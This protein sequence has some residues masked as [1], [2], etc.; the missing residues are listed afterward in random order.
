VNLKKYNNRTEAG[1]ILTEQLKEYANRADVI[2]LALPR[3]GVPVAYE[4]AQ[5][6][7]VPLDVFIVRKLGMPGQEELAIGALA[8]D[9]STVFNDDLLRLMP[10]PPEIIDEI[11]ASEKIELARRIS[12]YRGNQ[13]LPHLENKIIILVDDGIA[14]GATMRAAITVLQKQSLKK[15]I[16]AV[17]VAALDTAKEI[18]AMVDQFICPLTPELFYSVGSWYSD[19]P[20]TTDTEV[21]AL[22]NK[23]T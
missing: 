9:G 2:V 6:L 15:L 16:V 17:P 14:T 12:L 13:P 11:I 23:N 20:Q 3:G 19:F 1:K 5:T 18:A 7:A 8:M 4:I 10:F 21:I 22:L